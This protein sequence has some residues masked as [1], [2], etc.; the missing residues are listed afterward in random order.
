MRTVEVFTNEGEFPPDH[1][2]GQWVGDEYNVYIVEDKH[3]CVYSAAVLYYNEDDL[4]AGQYT[5]EEMACFWTVD[6]NG[7]SNGDDNYEY[8]DGSYGFFK[9]EEAAHADAKRA[10]RLMVEDHEKYIQFDNQVNT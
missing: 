7:E 2:R 8:G 1:N 6:E 3:R 9:T 5:W 10:I 4:E